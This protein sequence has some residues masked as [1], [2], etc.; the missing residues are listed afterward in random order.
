MGIK[1]NLFV[2]IDTA[3][4]DFS[5][6]ALDLEGTELMAPST[7]KHNAEDYARF[8]GYTEAIAKITN[9]TPIFGIESTGVYHIALYDFLTKNNYQV[10]V[11]N[12]LEVR[13]MHK[14]RIRKTKT[15]PID[16][17]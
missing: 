11:F 10:R 17:R 14:G 6:Y 13:G 2:G 16:A 7:C 8:L 12:G 3:K 15:D 9:T 4:E 5:V 1:N